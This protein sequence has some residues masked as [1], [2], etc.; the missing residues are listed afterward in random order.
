MGLISTS[1]RSHS[2]HRFPPERR[3]IDPPQRKNRDSPDLIQDRTFVSS[4][5]FF[6]SAST[7]CFQTTFLQIS[8]KDKHRNTNPAN[9]QNIR[10]LKTPLKLICT[11]RNMLIH[12]NSEL[13]L[14][15]SGSLLG[16]V[17]RSSPHITRCVVPQMDVS[18][19]DMT[20]DTSCDD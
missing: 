1:L 5:R 17:T 19:R 13:K 16:L 8:I 12:L 15:S 18:G 3:R 2:S 4:A 9:E 10:L 6:I 14:W 11:S 7:E 20:T